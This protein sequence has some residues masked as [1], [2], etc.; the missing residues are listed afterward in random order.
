MS[1]SNYDEDKNKRRT[2][3]GR[4]VLVERSHSFPLVGF[5]SLD[6]PRYHVMCPGFHGEEYPGNNGD[7]DGSSRVNLMVLI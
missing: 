2:H 5:H 7:L 3:K 4:F 6:P 1:R